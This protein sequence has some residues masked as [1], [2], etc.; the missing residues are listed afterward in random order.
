MTHQ[1]K[2][3]FKTKYQMY[4]ALADTTETMYVVYVI[5]LTARSDNTMHTRARRKSLGGRYL[6]M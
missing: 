3:L 4:L 6:R 5:N 1:K 2:K